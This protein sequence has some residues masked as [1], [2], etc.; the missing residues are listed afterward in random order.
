VEC[1]LDGRRL[2]EIEVAAEWRR[3]E[4]PL[5]RLARGESTFTLACG[6]PAVVAN[7]IRRNGDPRAL[8][9]ALGQWGLRK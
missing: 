2:R 6:G 9:L 8:C 5:D 1:L 7:D 3:Y 4:V